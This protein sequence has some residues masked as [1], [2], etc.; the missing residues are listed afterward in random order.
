MILVAMDEGLYFQ[1][2]FS[3]LQLLQVEFTNVA[4]VSIWKQG[5]MIKCTSL[6]LEY[7]VC[8]WVEYYVIYYYIETI[9]C[10]LCCME[11]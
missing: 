3:V 4:I 11:T 8:I 1:L 6:F 2:G 5:L 7:L 10:V 9:L